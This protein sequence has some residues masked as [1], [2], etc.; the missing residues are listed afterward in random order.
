LSS[1]VL[2]DDSPPLKIAAGAIASFYQ[3]ISEKLPL[4]PLFFFTGDPPM[5]TKNAPQSLTEFEVIGLK[6]P[7]DFANG[8][9][10]HDLSQ[11]FDP[12][13]NDLQ[14][15]W[16]DA[17]QKPIAVMEERFKKAIADIIP[18]PMLGDHAHYSL[19]PT[20]SNSIDAV[21]A[22]LKSKN[23]KAGLIEPVFDNLYLLLKRRQV[24]LTPIYEQDF[25]NLDVLEA[26]IKLNDLDALLLVS[27]NNPTGFQ[28]TIEE[29]KAV[30]ALCEK[31]GVTLILDA[32]FGFYSRNG[33]DEYQILADTGIEYIVV[34]DTGKTW[35][36][37]ELK[38]SL[39]AYSSS[40][41]PAMREIY[42]EVYLCHSNFSVGLL[43]CLIEHTVKE[44][45][46]NTVWKE[47]DRRRE[48]L[49]AALDGTGMTMNISNRAVPLP[50]AWVNCTATGLTDL[51]VIDAMKVHHIALLPG[52]FFYWN[53]PG[54]F[55]NHIRVSLLRPNA[56]FD[57]GVEAL[58]RAVAG[59]RK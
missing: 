10:Y 55:T 20:A 33:Y 31:M 28:L 51:E 2:F 59:L 44:G 38:V 19:F 41:A 39:M 12:V 35:P 6:T 26:K 45:L 34:E 11:A 43:S 47:V 24:P 29:F 42:E 21:S 27:P 25:I 13:M 3:V 50:L 8:H 58:G 22:W 7:Y 49:A 1:I 5:E 52:R 40:I 14:A 54:Q 15:I 17:K 56:V 57:K 16:A 32:T 4:F 37:Q 48:K 9:A 36:T 53:T 46:V 30:C 18:S 23:Y